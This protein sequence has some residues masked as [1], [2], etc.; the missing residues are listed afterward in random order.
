MD[1]GR[2]QTIESLIVTALIMSIRR[3]KTMDRNLKLTINCEPR[4]ARL[5]ERGC[6]KCQRAA[7]ETVEL[8]AAYGSGGCAM[9]RQ[10]LVDCLAACSI[11]DRWEYKDKAFFTRAL[12]RDVEDLFVV[13]E[14]IERNWYRGDSELSANRNRERWTEYNK[15][16]RRK[17]YD[18]RYAEKQKNEKEGKENENKNKKSIG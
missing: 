3:R 1:T 7:A 17:L 5:T 6:L 10:D 18:Q 13:F 15:N 16:G 11:C 8:I 12:R 9:V 2:R 4:S 14:R